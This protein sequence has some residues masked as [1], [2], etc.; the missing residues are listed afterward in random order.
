[1]KSK[2]FVKLGWLVIFCL[3]V[4]NS[5]VAQAGPPESGGLPTGLHQ[6]PQSTEVFWD[7]FFDREV[8]SLGVHGAVMVMVAGDEIVFAK[9]YGFADAANRIPIDPGSTIIRA[10]SIAKTVTA[11]A[12]MQLAES[13]QLDLDAD[14]NEYLTAF[15]IPD[16]FSEPVT[17]R[18]LINM[19]GGF[20]TRAVG[21]SA[22][23]RAEVRPLGEYLAERMPPR[24][25]PPGRYRRY[26]DHEIALAGYLVESISGMSYETYVRQHIFEP[27]E[28]NDSSILLPDKDLPRV[29]LGY[30]VGAGQDGA[31]PLSYYYLNDAPG[32]GFNTTAMDMAHYLMAHLGNG[33]YQ[34]SDGKQSRIFNEATAEQFHQTAFRYQAGMPGQANSFDERFY[35]GR[36][37]LRKQGGAPGMQNDLVLLPEENLGF[38]LFYNSEGTALRNDWENLIAKTYLSGEISQPANLRLTSNSGDV[39]AGNYVGDYLEVSDQTSQTTIVRVQALFDPDLWMRVEEGDRSSLIIG[40]QKYYQVE[41]DLFQNPTSGALKAFELDAGGEARFLFQDRFAY[42]RIPW[43][44]TP[45]VQLGLLGF[46]I[47]IF[48]VVFLTGLYG[49]I[50]RKKPNRLLPFLISGLNLTFLSGLAWILLPVATGGD[51]WQLSFDPSFELRLVLAIPWLTSFLAVVLLFDTILTW[52]SGRH[53]LFTRLFNSLILTGAAVF[54]YFLHT[55][56]LF[57]WRF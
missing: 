19:T 12:I 42:Q 41:P 54:T 34:G 27:L 18:H 17:A 28:M 36:R 21:I 43:L 24:V 37:Y 38:Y 47:L 6:E 46:A 16:T 31:Y 52:K 40:G 57:G 23:S 4:V 8:E 39:N 2:L 20:D 50:G 7:S 9:G 1:M 3:T 53:K 14:V 56:N 48:L 32:A 35:N 49:L 33:I 30:P 55:W 5:G 10:G 15:K 45:T 25:L 51:K 29:A 44:H 13:G 22:H 11:T 26:N